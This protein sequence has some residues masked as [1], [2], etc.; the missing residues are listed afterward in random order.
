MINPGLNRKFL[1]SDNSMLFYEVIY[2]FFLSYLIIRRFFPI[3][4]TLNNKQNDSLVTV[5]DYY[6][7]KETPI[8]EQ[9]KNLLIIM[10]QPI[11]LKDVEDFNTKH[12]LHILS[13]SEKNI[14][15]LEK[16]MTYSKNLS[17]L[18]LIN[19]LKKSSPLF[20][21]H[22]EVPQ[23][24]NDQVKIQNRLTLATLD[25]LKGNLDIA[26]ISSRAARN[27]T[28]DSDFIHKVIAFQ[29]VNKI[30]LEGQDYIPSAQILSVTIEMPSKS[31]FMSMNRR[32]IIK[33]IP[34][35]L[36]DI[37]RRNSF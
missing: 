4:K 30:S 2:K 13:L 16:F 12:M 37:K 22:P 8:I 33:E 29:A 20:Q 26:I 25:P 5:I 9:T 23:Q 10:D 7:I 1:F 35:K 24:K 18:K 17:S 11:R 21:L 31:L 6:L 15:L 14:S 27:A 19:L 32:A 36:T 3:K 34:E 28:N